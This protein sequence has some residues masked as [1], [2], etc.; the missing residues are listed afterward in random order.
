MTMAEMAEIEMA[1]IQ[2]LLKEM[3][4]EIRKEI[5]KNAKEIENVR[6]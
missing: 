5:Q 1:K 2:E 3:V 6:N 4:M